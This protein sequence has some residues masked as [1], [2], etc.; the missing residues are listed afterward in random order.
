M[1]R[2]EILMMIN[3]TWFTDEIYIPVWLDQKCLGIYNAVNSEK[4]YIPVWLDQK[5]EHQQEL[6]DNIVLIYIPVWLDQK[7]IQMVYS[8]FKIINLHSSMVRLEISILFLRIFIF[9]KFTFQYGQIRNAVQRKVADLKKAFTFQYGQI[10]NSGVM[11]TDVL[12]L[13][14]YIPVWLDQK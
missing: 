3:Q 5:F 9:I 7:C 2:L 10:R 8:S 11:Y 4:I 14:I 6:S 12:K 1:V 13:N